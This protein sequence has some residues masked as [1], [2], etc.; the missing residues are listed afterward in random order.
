MM[1][2]KGAQF[3]DTEFGMVI[4]SYFPRQ[5]APKYLK[6]QVNAQVNGIYLMEDAIEKSGKPWY[7][8]L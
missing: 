8:N 6:N 5:N 1:S 3:V 2:L 7:D 4:I